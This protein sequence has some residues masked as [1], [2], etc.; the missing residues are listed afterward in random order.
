MPI[1]ITR[2]VSG[3][4]TNSQRND[5][6]LGMVMH[7]VLTFCSVIAF[8]SSSRPP[9]FFSF[10]TKLLTAFSLH[11]SSPSPFFQ[12]SSRLTT[13]DANGSIDVI[14]NRHGLRNQ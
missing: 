9:V 10:L 12:L 5:T 6:H 8:S 4:E 13:G 14:G 3:S 2:A 11:F 7:L 1:V